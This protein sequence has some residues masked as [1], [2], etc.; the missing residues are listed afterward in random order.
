LIWKELE[1]PQT[2]FPIQCTVSV[3]KKKFPRAADRNRIRRRV[4]EA[5]R[6]NKHW[7]YEALD[8]HA[9]QYAFMILY[10]AKE[11][12]PY[13]DIEKAMKKMLTRFLKKTQ[14]LASTDNQK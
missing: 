1:A 11:E 9:P 8:K 3:A 14:F 7:L 2:D 10:V 12:L 4:K 5:Y 13:E 6:L